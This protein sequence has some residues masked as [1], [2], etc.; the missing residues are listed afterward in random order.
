MTDTFLLTP[1]GQNWLNQIFEAKA[2]RSGTVIRR[3][4]RDVDRMVGREAF[5]HEIRRRGFSVVEN[6]GQYVI[7][8]N[9]EGVRRLA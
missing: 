7:F 9:A 5:V 2:A 1:R 3:R 4:C 6:A 8:C